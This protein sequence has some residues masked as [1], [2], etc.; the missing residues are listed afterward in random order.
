MTDR[1]EILLRKADFTKESA[2]R[3]KLEK[4]LFS[5]RPADLMRARRIPDTGLEEL[6]A[7]GAVETLPRKPEEKAPPQ[8]FPGEKGDGRG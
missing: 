2:L 8:G 5:R 7:A 6:A 1:F 3:G 4:E